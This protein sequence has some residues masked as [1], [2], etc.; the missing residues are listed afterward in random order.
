MTTTAVSTLQAPSDLDVPRRRYARFRPDSRRNVLDLARPVS[1]APSGAATLDDSSVALAYADSDAVPRTI[2]LLPGE[3]TL[4]R[5]VKFG[6][7]NGCTLAS[8]VLGMAAIFLSMRGEPRVAAALLVGCVVFD[9]VDGAL[10]RKMGVASPFGAQMDSM[11]DMC[12][13]G[14][15]APVVVYASMHGSAPSAL[16]AA[17]CAMIAIGS[18][19][20]LARFNVSPK[21]GRFFCGVPTTMTAA[22][23]GIAV[24][25][26]L[27]LPGLVAVTA[28]A[29]LAIAMVSGFPYA[30]VGRLAK[31]PVWLWIVP[32]AG[33]LVAPQ[34]TFACLVALYLV[35][36]PLLWLHRRGSARRTA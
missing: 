16:I 10:A 8:L 31:L 32:I 9:G 13:F 19:I 11:A 26:G 14:M 4:A 29:M 21:D 23:M 17:A 36:G 12:S 20:R 24:L 34:V 6:I 25:I 27:H 33:L 18:A 30:K 2:P 28:V 22:V 7:A 1:P 35:S 15:A 3:K 5:R